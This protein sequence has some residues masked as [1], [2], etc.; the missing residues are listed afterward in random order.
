MRQAVKRL[1]PSP[2]ALLILAA[3]ATVRLEV[4]RHLLQRPELCHFELIG[5][6]RI[7]ERGASEFV[8][9]IGL[10]TTP[11]PEG[12]AVD[13]NVAVYWP[14]FSSVAQHA[15]AGK[16]PETIRVRPW[17]FA[18]IVVGFGRLSGDEA[19]WASIRVSESGE[20]AELVERIVEAY[21][22]YGDA[23]LQRC[24]TAE[25]FLAYLDQHPGAPGTWRIMLEFLLRERV[26]GTSAACSALKAVGTRTKW[27]QKQEMW[28]A[29]NLCRLN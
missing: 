9:S 8:S 12:H 29:E 15:R 6:E 27:E 25:G 24:T 17:E 4:L 22:E 19:A 11:V 2:R 26:Q 18:C 21:E 28:L 1:R 14:R 20:L 16:S 23:F 13:V 7:V 5:S 3:V 10:V